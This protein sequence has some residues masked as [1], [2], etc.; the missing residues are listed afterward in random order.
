MPN[1]S[2][3][4]DPW[5]DRNVEFCT[6]R[7][8]KNGYLPCSYLELLGLSGF[9]SYNK[10]RRYLRDPSQ[11]IGVDKD[12]SVIAT[13]RNLGIPGSTIPRP[14]FQVVWKD[15]AYGWAVELSRSS[16]PIGVFN[17]DDTIE[18][19]SDGWYGWGTNLDLIAS[20]I[21]PNTVR[22]LGSC[23]IFI[24]ASFGRFDPKEHGTLLI[25][26][27][28]MITS[29]LLKY[30]WAGS[31]VDHGILIGSDAELRQLE[32]T[33]Y[34]GNVGCFDIYTS[35]GR[36]LRMATLRLHFNGCQV[37]AHRSPKHLY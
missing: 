23:S 20:C 21:A 17:F 13:Y 26:H 6:T 32:S 27:A 16:Q 35:E 1:S 25:R 11:F 24:N 36:I 12:L 19:G 31:G 3:Q 7:V 33:T 4:K 8:I 22:K 30:R 2:Y 37:T 9:E 29:A 28:N 14:E 15:D 34:S 18:A 5:R 10:L